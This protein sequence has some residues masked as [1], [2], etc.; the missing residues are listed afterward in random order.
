MNIRVAVTREGTERKLFEGA[1][2]RV[3]EKLFEGIMIG[4]GGG[5]EGDCCFVIDAAGDVKLVY[6]RDIKVLDSS[7]L[8]QLKDQRV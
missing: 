4:T 1:M 6:F 8:E 3:Q 2:I 7:I 5:D